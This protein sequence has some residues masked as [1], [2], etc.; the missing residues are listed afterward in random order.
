MSYNKQLVEEKMEKSLQALHKDFASLRTGR[1]SIS[2]LDGIM[3]DS[4]GSKMPLNQVGSVSALDGQTLSVSVW[5]KSVV[6]SVEK[7]IRES[8]LG[9]NPVVDG[10]LLR[11]PVPP[12]SEE[13]RIEI[14]K[15]AGKY[16]ENAKISVRNARQDGMNTIKAD[17]KAKEISEDDAKR[18]SDEV[19]KLTD[20]FVNEIS[21]ALK[22]KE[23]DIKKV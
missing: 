15:V 16:A 6:Q 19:Q 4:Y 8:E 5:D 2:M 14:A 13:R 9:L 1:A 11:I 20:K 10:T 3:V 22:T 17:E 18:L 23:E 21:Q 12:L 7:A